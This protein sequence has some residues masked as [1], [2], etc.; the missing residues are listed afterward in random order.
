MKLLDLEIE[1]KEK[2]KILNTCFIEFNI[3]ILK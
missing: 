2:K 1:L 3:K